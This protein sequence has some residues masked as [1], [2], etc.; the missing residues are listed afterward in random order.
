MKKIEADSIQH[1]RVGD[2]AEA[3]AMPL[4]GEGVSVTILESF[5]KGVLTPQRYS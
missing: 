5:E 3:V 1:L 2:L 4:G